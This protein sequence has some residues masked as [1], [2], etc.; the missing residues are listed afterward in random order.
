[1]MSDTSMADRSMADRSMAATLIPDA[2]TH[3]NTAISQ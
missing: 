1:M 3:Q 2:Q